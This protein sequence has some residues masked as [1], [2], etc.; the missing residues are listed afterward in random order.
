M[1][2]HTKLLTTLTV[3]AATLAAGA[4]FAQEATRTPEIDNFVSTKSRAEVV[5]ATKEADRQGLIPRNDAEAVRLAEKAFRPQLS[6]AQVRA[7]AAEANRLGLIAYGEAGA[8][9]ATPEQLEQIRAAGLRAIT[10]KAQ[11]AGK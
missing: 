10:D 8:P 1:F 4:S 2:N 9:Q 11:L 5:A 7:E 6:R 3:V